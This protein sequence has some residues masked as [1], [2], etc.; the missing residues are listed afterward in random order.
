VRGTASAYTDYHDVMPERYRGLCG[1]LTIRTV[2]LKNVNALGFGGVI[3]TAALLWLLGWKLHDGYD[4][5]I[6]IGVVIW[7]RYLKKC[8]KWT[9]KLVFIPLSNTLFGIKLPDGNEH[10]GMEVDVELGD[11]RIVAPV[12]T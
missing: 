11:G 10:R 5:E 1:L 2:G 3:F 7:E 8:W 9:E 6:L 4:D 12:A